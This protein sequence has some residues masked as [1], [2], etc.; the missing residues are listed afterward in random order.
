MPT[1]Q[2]TDFETN[3]LPTGT[4]FVSNAKISINLPNTSINAPYP[5]YGDVLF[6]LRLRDSTSGGEILGITRTFTIQDLSSFNNSNSDVTSIAEGGSVT[7]YVY[8]TQTQNGPLYYS[9]LGNVNYNDFVGGNVGSFT[10]TNNYGSFTLQA[11]ADLSTQVERGERF[12]VQIRSGSTS[13]TVIGTSE[14]VDIQDSSNVTTVDSISISPLSIFE[15]EKST[16]TVNTINGLGNAGATLYYTIT[17][18]ANIFSSVS[19]SII[20]ND[21][22]G[23]INVIPEG[24]FAIE[25][26]EEKYF[27]VQVR[28]GSTG[29][30]IL[31]TSSNVYVADIGTNEAPNAQISS[32]KD[33]V[34]TP[35]SSIGRNQTITI[36]ANLYNSTNGETLYYDTLGNVSST[37]FTSG[38]TGSVVT[39]NNVANIQLTTSSTYG[40]N[41]KVRLKRAS[42]GIVL[43]QTDF[44][45]PA[46]VLGGLVEVSGSTYTHIFTSSET[47]I[48]SSPIPGAKVLVVAGGGASGNGGSPSVKGAGGGGGAGGMVLVP[49]VTIPAGEYNIVVGAGGVNGTPGSFAQA[50]RGANTTAFGYI[51]LGGGRGA[52]TT[53]PGTPTELAVYQGGS[54]AGAGW[55]SFGRAGQQV[56]GGTGIQTV[57]LTIPADSRTYGYGGNGG[58]A[59]DNN[60]TGGGGGGAAGNGTNYNAGGVGGAARAVPW[61]PASY[62][63]SGFARYFGGGGNGGG[64][65]GSPA[66]QTVR[67]VAGGSNTGSGGGGGSA[68]NNVAYAGGSGIVAIQYTL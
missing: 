35:S 1:I 25:S 65:T 57:S 64:Q 4:V 36:L 66:G 20:I 52:A 32:V 2:A 37:S 51:A 38:N 6:K 7:F 39:A 61:V 49:S 3:V 5:F 42:D 14:Y 15:T 30:T 48:I 9:T 11:N 21:D 19:G 12:A 50:N 68:G 55:V 34:A 58:I 62:G 26:G 40:G 59:N 28:Q 27:A 60:A 29:G 22:I 8:T 31:A 63:I 56:A 33:I 13:G 23:Q 46:P 47:A 24:G 10:L 53:N 41:F 45:E 18:N 67:N 44:L 16:L 54:A 17:G 43:G